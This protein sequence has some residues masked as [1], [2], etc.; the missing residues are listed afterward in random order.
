MSEII[1]PI[2]G[3]G[4]SIKLQEKKLFS[5]IGVVGC[6]RDGQ[7]IV[8]LTASAGLEVVF[9][10]ISNDK[11]QLA[12]DNISKNLDTKVENWGLTASEK[13][14]IMSKITGSLNYEDLKG[15]DFV[16]ECIRYDDHTGERNKM[17][18]KEV[19]MNLERILAP[20][21]VIATNASTII[22]TELASDLEHK[23]R[24]ISLHFL[25]TQPEAKILEIVKGL[26]TSDEVF[27]KMKLFA[28]LIK[29]DYISVQESNGLVSLRLFV[30]M[31][32]EACQ[33]LMENVASLEDIDKLLQV[34]YGYRLGVFRSADILGIEKMVPLMNNMFDEYGDKKYKPSPLLLRLFRAKHFGVRTRKGFYLYDENGKLTGPA[35]LA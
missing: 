12:L 2:E 34:G 22:I 25:V 16:I 32:N 19:F 11:I 27:E 31:L 17:M 3:F 33:M 9:V 29:H 10:E 30:T 28:K 21:A 23:E 24:C 1:E 35:A 5:K 15:C 18:R 14:S 4:L 20:D 6:G 26:Y 7:N 13:R 8:G